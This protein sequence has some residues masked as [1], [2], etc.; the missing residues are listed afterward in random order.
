MVTLNNFAIRFRATSLVKAAFAISVLFLGLVC[1]GPDALARDKKADFGRLE[2]TTNPEAYPLLVDGSP[3]G[4]TAGAPRLV[5]LPPGRHTVEIQ[6]PNGARWIRDFDVARNKKNCI[7]LNYKPRIITIAKSLCPFP[8]NVSSPSSVNDGDLIT[9]SSDVSYGGTAPLNYA[10][11]I[12]PSTARVVSGAGTNTITVDTTGLGRQRVSAALLVDDGSGNPVCRQ[13]ARTAA[14]VT[15]LAPPPVNA[16]RFD[17]YPSIAFDDEKARLDNLAIEMQ[18]DPNATGYIFV[19]GGR[20]S[21][22]GQ[23]DRLGSRAK[24]YL[25][26][27]RGIDARR[28]VVT[29]GGYRETDYFELWLVPQGAQPPQ[30]TPTVQPGDVRPGANPAPGR[31]LRPRH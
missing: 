23:A 24:D 10:W 1:A 18:N 6:F 2:I 4:T 19:Y 25:A 7:A 12:S 3:S 29:D 5:D 16:R 30:P 13:A 21:R 14:S 11:T 9:F 27:S 15:A 17:E 28:L 22:P 31:R 26:N 8:V 20:T